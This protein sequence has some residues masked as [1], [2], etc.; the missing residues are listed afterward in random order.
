MS[1][2]A[3]KLSPQLSPQNYVNSAANSDVVVLAPTSWLADS[4]IVV[5]ALILV[6]FQIL[7]GA[8]TYSGMNTFGIRAE[9]NPLLR[10]FMQSVGVLP[11][12]AL[13]KLVCIGV[14]I[15]LCSQARKI[16]WLPTALTC[17][18]GVYAIAAI[19]PWSVLLIG[20]Y[21]A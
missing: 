2:A 10:S 13:T 17:I 9:G 6:G 16:S 4:R 8:L 12:I 20:E 7:D 18:A 3:L 14:V 11:A 21:L 19:L 1:N 15:G 5:L